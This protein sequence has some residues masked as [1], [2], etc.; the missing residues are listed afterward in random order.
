[1]YTIIYGVPRDVFSMLHACVNRYII[2]DEVYYNSC[3]KFNEL[4]ISYDSLTEPV[5]F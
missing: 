3:M 4:N 5:T 2:T 1:M